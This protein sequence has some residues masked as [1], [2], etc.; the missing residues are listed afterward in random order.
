M[1]PGQDASLEVE[2]VD[3]L[4]PQRLRIRATPRPDGAIGDDGLASVNRP[5]G[6]KGIQG[7][8]PRQHGHRLL[9]RRAHV[10]KHGGRRGLK[11]EK[12]LGRDFFHVGKVRAIA[13]V[14]GLDSFL[15][16]GSIQRT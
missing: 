5:G 8:G 7:D 3:A 2:Y 16:R 11:R 6:F 13:L 4:L 10:H 12:A 1:R 15:S 14:E 9:L